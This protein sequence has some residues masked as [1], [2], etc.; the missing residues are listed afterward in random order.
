MVSNT[1]TWMHEVGAGWLMTSLAPSPRMV[2]AVQAATSLP[3][4]LLALPSGA[5]ADIVDRRRYLIATQV[6]MACAA[7]LL[8]FLTLA[9]FTT[10]WILL[11]GTF[12]LGTGMAM[13]APAWGATTP[14]LVPRVDLPGAVA[15]NSMGMNVSRAI[16]PALA[17]A[18][19]GAAGSG[20]VFLLNAVSFV[21]VIGVLVWWRRER[22]RSALPVER[23]LGA[24]K[25]GL[26]Y[27]RNAPML[28]DAMLRGAAFFV[29][30]SASW[31]LLPL[32]A[33]QQ[34]GGGAALYGWLV[35][36]IG[37]GAVAGALVLPAL[38]RHVSRDRLVAGASL[39]FATSLAILGLSRQAWLVAA[40][41]VLNGAAW[42]AVLSSL[43]T[44]AQL[45]LPSWV[46]ARGLAAFMAVFMGSMA[47]GSLLWGHVAGEIGIARAMLVAAVAMAVAAL[48]T[49]RFSLGIADRV[50][51]SPSLHWPA[52]AQGKG[53]APDR[54]PVMVTVEYRIDPR[55]TDNFLALLREMR[56]VRRR[57]GA[58][59][60]ETFIDAADPARVLEV[61]MVESW[62]EHLRQHDRVTVED[63][64]IQERLRAC[65]QGPGEPVIAHFVAGGGPGDAGGSPWWPTH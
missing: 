55:D 3:I 6:W 33:R 12:A 57:D 11:I 37:A 34:L 29:P 25:A 19:I 26:R 13:A 35:A 4:F 60:W 32:I 63:R 48:L 10:P 40:A 45:A 38:R 7:G 18:I 8:G 42:I 49:R 5:L 27:T 44:V 20:A 36:C 15:L 54:G 30:G 28:L 59:F 53:I 46:R 64:L 56:R 50:D 43:F 58:F 9:G 39:L 31:A 21:F 52:P 2:A 41:M 47:G 1:G 17:G 62:L 22:R 51:L 24:L 23:F 65:H 16:G 61:F 14:E